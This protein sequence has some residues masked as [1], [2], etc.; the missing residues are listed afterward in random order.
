V[1]TIAVHFLL[2]T[3]CCS[4]LV[5][6]VRPDFLCYPRC[7]ISSPRSASSFRAQPMRVAVPPPPACFRVDLVP[8]LDF[9]AHPFYASR[10]IP[11]AQVHLSPGQRLAVIFPCR[12]VSVKSGSC[13][14]HRILLCS[15]PFCWSTMVVLS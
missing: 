10:T 4:L 13:F 15:I 9:S 5:Q 6:L 1:C 2:F 7:L 11:I 8:V 12:P 3:F 14:S